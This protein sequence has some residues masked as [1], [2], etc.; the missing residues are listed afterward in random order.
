MEKAALPDQVQL[1]QGSSFYLR[2]LSPS[3]SG[4]YQIL[5]I[6]ASVPWL[7]QLNVLSLCVWLSSFECVS[8]NL[9]FFN[10][11]RRKHFLRV[12][13]PSQRTYSSS[14]GLQRISP[15]P[16]WTHNADWALSL[17]TSALFLS[18]QKCSIDQRLSLPAELM[19]NEGTIK[20]IWA[21]LVSLQPCNC[22]C[23][24]TV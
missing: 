22:I 9:S 5:H 7:L 12:K 21:V 13:H 18:S 14:K 4:V 1:S 16:A 24:L 19:G 10:A 20:R 11:C 15:I 23:L 8:N 2:N 17:N 6:C 3:P